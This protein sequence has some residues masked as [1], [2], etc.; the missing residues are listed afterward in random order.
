MKKKKS[1]KTTTNKQET[2]KKNK[3]IKKNELYEW[4]YRYD[5]WMILE[6]VK[7]LT[8]MYPYD[9]LYQFLS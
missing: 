9:Y 6:E 8:F 3:V 1:N 4:I 5:F 2:N 7:W